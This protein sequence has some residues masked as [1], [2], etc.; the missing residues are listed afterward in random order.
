MKLK[1]KLKNIGNGV[2]ITSLFAVPIGIQLHRNYT[3][4]KEIELYEEL[5]NSELVG[6]HLGHQDLEKICEDEG[7]PNYE[8]YESVVVKDNNLTK[9]ENGK[10]ILPED[11]IVSVRDY[12]GN[13]RSW[14]ENKIRYNNE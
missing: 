1:Q 3:I 8:M 12:D 11:G 6:A 5:Y 10:I 2:M 13:G 14:P 9:D 4:Q 7:F